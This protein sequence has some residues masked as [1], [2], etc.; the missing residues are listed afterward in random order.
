[1]SHFTFTKQELLDALNKLSPM[2]ETISFAD[3]QHIYS[4]RRDEIDLALVKAARLDYTREGELEVDASAI[5][6]RADDES[7]AYVQAWVWV[8]TPDASPMSGLCELVFK[9]PTEES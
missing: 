3:V 6:S 4:Q 7:G 5:T 1:M 2:S 8:S 9:D